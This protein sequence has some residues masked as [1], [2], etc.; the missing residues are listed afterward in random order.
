MW[1][2]FAIL[3]IYVTAIILLIVFK[4]WITIGI[5]YGLGIIL[6]VYSFMT[7]EECP[8]ELKDLFE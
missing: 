4:C 5:I 2:F 3:F 7:S 8:E 6:F 1:K